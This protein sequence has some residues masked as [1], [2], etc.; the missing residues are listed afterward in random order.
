MFGGEKRPLLPRPASVNEI[1]AFI[2][3]YLLIIGC[4]QIKTL[5]PADRLAPEEK[6]E[7]LVLKAVDR[8][9]AQNFLTLGNRESR[10]E[11]INWFWQEHSSLEHDL[12]L[13]RANKAREA[14]GNLDLFG[15]ER[16]PIYIRYGPPRRE[17][18]TPQPVT[19]DTSR[20]FVN[21]AEIWTYD[22]LGLQFDF[23]KTGIAF[24][25]VGRNRFGDNWFPPALEPVDYGKPPPE[26]APD[27]RPLDFTFNLYR[28]AQNHDTVTVELHYGI[29]ARD[30]ALNPER[31]GAGN[32]P[33]PIVHIQFEFQPRKGS[34][35]VVTSAGWFGY[36][37]PPS[38]TRTTPPDRV[39]GRQVFS[40]P[41]DIYTV[42]G[43][44]R[45]L[46]GRAYA[47]CQKELN[48]I[49]YIR[50]AQPCSDMIFYALIDST[51]QSPQFERPDWRRVIPLVVPEVQPGGVVYLLYEVYHLQVDSLHQHRI[52][53]TYELMNLPRRQ[54]VIV[55]APTRFI[56]HQGA[57]AVVV[58]RLHTM[59][60]NPGE[61]LIV[62][63][64]QDLNGGRSLTLTG[65]FNIL[66]H[67]R[68]H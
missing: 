59:D 36:P 17:E 67:Q 41:A 20:I 32:E 6:L 39:V 11:Y 35:P 21:P 52:E 64:V 53:A 4:S 54:S 50:R 44:A 51:F 55:P 37:V 42:T 26:P 68:P 63:R 1:L 49:D 62:A 61:Y 22:S 31:T 9:A 43:T 57:T 40:L 8:T 30:A 29:A 25:L 10:T 19:T 66:K 28:L 38:S 33:P 23:V 60:L 34:N 3:C 45:T 56:S 5:S 24:K 46:N 27:A 48:L 16:I 18:Y 65:T 15:D 14:F 13:E 12:L 47:R 7:Y 2:L 58:E